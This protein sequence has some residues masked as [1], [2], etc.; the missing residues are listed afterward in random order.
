MSNSI[1]RNALDGICTWQNPNLTLRTSLWNLPISPNIVDR[2]PLAGIKTFCSHQA[3]KVSIIFQSPVSFLIYQE[4]TDIKHDLT[5]FALLFNRL[6]VLNSYMSKFEDYP[7][8]TLLFPP[9][10]IHLA[11]PNKASERSWALT[12]FLPTGTHP[13]IITLP[14]TVLFC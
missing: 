12:A 2:M 14:P 8:G 6:S 1:P 11:S 9:F 5:G 4:L 10:M 3:F 7:S 13:G